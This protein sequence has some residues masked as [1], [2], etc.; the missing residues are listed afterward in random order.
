M[1]RIRGKDTKPEMTIRRGLHARGFRFR[2]HVKDLPGRPDIVLPR[3]RAVI[4]V[5]G[6][7]WHGHE[8]CG[9]MP[10]SRQE[11][12]GPKIM[13]NRERDVRNEWA[14]QDIGWRLLVVWECAMVGRGRWGS[15]GLL[16]AVETWV[17][18]DD[19]RTDITG[20]QVTFP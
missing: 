20:S 13:N 5:R 16:D 18:S 4:E 2:L 12:W 7:F 10:K 8:G 17:R 15:D 14:L 11:F 1:S 3:W 6:C 9:R 19:C